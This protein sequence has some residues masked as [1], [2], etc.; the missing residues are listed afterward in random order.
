MHRL[1]NG[2]LVCEWT[3]KTPSPGRVCIVGDIALQDSCPVSRRDLTSDLNW[4]PVKGVYYVYAIANRFVACSDGKI[5]TSTDGL[6]W[7]FCQGIK[8]LHVLERCG[9]ALVVAGRYCYYQTFDGVTWERVEGFNRPSF[10]SRTIT[11]SDSRD[12]AGIFLWRDVPM[13][14]NL[15]GVYLGE[16]KNGKVVWSLIFQ[17]PSYRPWI[18][19]CSNRIVLGFPKRI[20][21]IDPPPDCELPDFQSG[22]AI[23]LHIPY[24]AGDVVAG[25]DDLAIRQD[26]SYSYLLRSWT[27]HRH[28]YLHPRQLKRIYNLL[29]A[30][31]R[32]FPLILFLDVVSFIAEAW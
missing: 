5:V 11:I 4:E 13:R 31:R 2:Q 14:S 6:S 10:I 16:V 9:Q 22:Y 1:S 21:I 29:L 26:S 18:V 23:H 25:T 20:Q 32:H 7:N 28:R 30:M 15:T 17:W 3:L 12:S 27:I 19:S 24:Y 8:E